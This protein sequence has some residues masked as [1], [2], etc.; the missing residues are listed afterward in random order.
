MP[1]QGKKKKESEKEEQELLKQ[2]EEEEQRILKENNKKENKR[3]LLENCKL[4]QTK[5]KGFEGNEAQ[6]KK[7]YDLIEKEKMKRIEEYQLQK[8]MNC[9]SLPFTEAEINTELNALESFEFK[10]N[11]D[12]YL[13]NLKHMNLVK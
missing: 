8:F 1:K 11:I 12:V 2:K 9:S 10:T 13:A 6:I 5:Y 7:Q 3:R 4:I